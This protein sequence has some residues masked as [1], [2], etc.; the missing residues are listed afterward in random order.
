MKIIVSKMI[1]EWIDGAGT[2]ERVLYNKINS[3]EDY[4]IDLASLE[5]E[6]NVRLED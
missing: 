2:H 6:N 1:V 4:I 5:E 3:S